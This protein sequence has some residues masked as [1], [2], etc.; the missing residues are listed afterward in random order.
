MDTYHLHIPSLSAL[1]AE[2]YF[3][4]QCQDLPP[5]IFPM[6]VHDTLEIYILLEGDVSF[7]VESSVYRLC[8][9]DAIISKPNEIHNCILNTRSTHKHLCL[10]FDPSSP[11]LFDAFLAHDFGK[12]NHI[13]P[14][15]PTKQRLLTV[16]DE[17][18]TA[19]ER[20]D[21]QH[22]FYLIL[23]ILHH[24]RRFTPAMTEP[25]LLPSTLSLVLQDIDENFNT[26]HSLNYLYQKYYVSQ[27]TLNRM[28]RTYLH[29]TPKAYLE[30]KRLAHSRLLLKQGKSVLAACIES[31]F[32]DYSNYIRLF[33][34]R[35]SITP[36]QYRD[37]E[38]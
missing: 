23:E 16:Y 11:F 30:A 37:G 29:T 34:K 26:I 36:R 21:K 5:R 17:F 18:Q 35:F 9:G 8:P 2:F 1:D 4:R 31:G 25:S 15:E 22:Q 14:D 24:L 12:N 7:A 19:T 33:R 13:V 27:S 10:W 20:E 6:H 38:N 28:F 32:P 3:E